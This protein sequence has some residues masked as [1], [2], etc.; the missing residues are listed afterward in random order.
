M[1]VAEAVEDTILQMVVGLQVVL[2]EEELEDNEVTVIQ[3]FQEL[4]G[5]VAVAVALELLLEEHTQEETVD[6]EL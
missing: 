1:Q 4:T 6:Q 5:L 2:V 3:A